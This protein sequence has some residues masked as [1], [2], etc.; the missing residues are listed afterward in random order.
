M[1]RGAALGLMPLETYTGGYCR[2]VDGDVFVFFTDG[3]YEAH[4]MRGEEFGI[5][6]MEKVLRGLMY[7]NA[8]EIVDG[9]MQAI[10]QFVGDEPVTDDI[11]IIAV[12]VTTKSPV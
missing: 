6:R 1:P 12:E 10:T 9:M 4:N 5:A 11:C 2:L 3:V 8:R 7:K